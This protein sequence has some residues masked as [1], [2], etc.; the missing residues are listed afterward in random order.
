MTT[1][2]RNELDRLIDKFNYAMLITRS[3]EGKIRARPM[4]I[5]GPRRGARLY[6]ATRVEKGKLGEIIQDSNVGV[7][8]QGG[9]TFLSISGRAEV[10]TDPDLIQELWSMPMRVWFP[11]GIDDPQL[12]LIRLE[13]CYAEYWD[14]SGLIR[15]EVLWESGKALIKGEIPEDD[16]LGAHAKII[17]P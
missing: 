10:V 3:L 2:A 17:D 6:F 15:L 11:Q 7:S 14:Q 4:M 9:N 12:T 16:P 5:V 13:P 8:L 1:N